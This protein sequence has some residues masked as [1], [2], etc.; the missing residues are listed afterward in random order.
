MMI[1]FEGDVD[2]KHPV[3]WLSWLLYLWIPVVIL[4]L[5]TACMQN[6]PYLGLF[7]YALL[8][9]IICLLCSMREDILFYKLY[10]IIKELRKC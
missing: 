5:V 7:Y 10:R 4:N 9:W 8:G 2:D 1:H 3:K 6:R